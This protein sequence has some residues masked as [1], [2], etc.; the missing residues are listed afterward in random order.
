MRTNLLTMVQQLSLPSL[1]GAASI[2]RTGF[3]FF[4]T[5]AMGLIAEASA[6]V[7]DMDGLGYPQVALADLTNPD[8]PLLEQA[9]VRLQAAL[10][11][12]RNMNHTN[13]YKTG[14]DKVLAPPALIRAR[15]LMRRKLAEF[16]A[17]GGSRQSS[18]TTYLPGSGT[19]FS[20]M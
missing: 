13:T 16:V 3:S 14:I 12:Q 15:M 2:D 11:Q 4:S 5:E 7:H 6:E 17:R 18:T 10:Q 20:L 19:A 8:E 1:P 9:F